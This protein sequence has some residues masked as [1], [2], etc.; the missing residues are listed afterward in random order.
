LSGAF[1]QARP[2]YAPPV[3]LVA[4]ED[5]VAILHGFEFGAIDGNACLR[6]KPLLPPSSQ[7]EA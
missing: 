5:L 4:R 3:D 2:L 1:A 6:Q 7:A